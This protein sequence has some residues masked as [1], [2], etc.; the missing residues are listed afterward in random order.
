MACYIRLFLQYPQHGKY[1]RNN[2]PSYI[3]NADGNQCFLLT[4][5]FLWHLAVSQLEKQH[6]EKALG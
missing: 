2:T 1:I 3:E 4:F 5:H 6:A